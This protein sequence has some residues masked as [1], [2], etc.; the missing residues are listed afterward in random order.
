[1]SASKRICQAV[2]IQ[3]VGKMHRVTYKNVRK[4]K[5][6]IHQY[7][8]KLTIGNPL[9]RLLCESQVRFFPQ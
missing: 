2:N 1:M 6:Y 5:F 4:R 8:C 7:R 3:I 9:L